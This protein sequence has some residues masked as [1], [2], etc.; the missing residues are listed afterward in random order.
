LL[1]ERSEF[2]GLLVDAEGGDAAGLSALKFVHFP[3]S[4]EV[5]AVGMESE[6][7]R[8]FGLGGEFGSG[9]SPVLAVE[10]RDVNAF[11]FLIGVG[12]EKDQTFIGT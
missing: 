3:H 9:Q 8:A 6:E 5:F 2:A 4:V 7:G 12:S 1:I 10:P 11:A